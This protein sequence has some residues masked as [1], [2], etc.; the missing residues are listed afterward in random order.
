MPDFGKTPTEDLWLQN[1]ANEIELQHN[2][3]ALV[4]LVWLEERVKKL[5]LLTLFK[6]SLVYL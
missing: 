1:A 3:E 6:D 2:H 5:E 4:R